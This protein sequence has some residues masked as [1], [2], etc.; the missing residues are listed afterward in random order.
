MAFPVKLCEVLSESSSAVKEWQFR[1][2]ESVEHLLSLLNTRQ[3]LDALSSDSAGRSVI[4]QGFPEVTDKLI[5][6]E[7]GLINSLFTKLEKDIA[8]FSSIASCLKR[9]RKRAWRLYSQNT[10]TS[11]EVSSWM[12]SSATEFSIAE[13][14]CWLDILERVFLQEVAIKEALLSC[15][16]EDCSAECLKT[17]LQ[18]WKEEAC[19][20]SV[21]DCV[22]RL[23]HTVA[24]H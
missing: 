24:S 15:M 13:R 18:Q 22:Q 20:A 8:S 1:Q 4:S 23:M 6:K 3:Q 10:R 19:V 11:L 5:F 17:S 12:E 21:S 2:Q 9:A 7:I 14:L 16:H